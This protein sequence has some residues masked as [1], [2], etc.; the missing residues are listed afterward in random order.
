MDLTEVYVGLGGNIGNPRHTLSEAL[1]ILQAHN[2]IYDL[3]TSRFYKTSPV[4]PLPQNHF[5]N[6][7][8]RFMTSLTPH[9]LLKVLQEIEQQ[10]G[11]KPKLKEEPRAI[12]CDIL[13]FGSQ[14]ISTPEL[15]I[16]H[17]LWRERLFVIIPLYELTKTVNL[18]GRGVPLDLQAELQTFQNHNNEKVQLLM[19]A[20]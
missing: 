7:V 3:K 17:P 5:V 10:L 9:T 4:S 8:C 18:P 6:G 14:S 15:V 11:K 12:D 19:E 2:A 1:K 20:L 13:L 16:P